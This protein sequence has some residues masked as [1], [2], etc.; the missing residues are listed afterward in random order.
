VCAPPESYFPFLCIQKRSG[1]LGKIQEQF[2]QRLDVKSERRGSLLPLEQERNRNETASK[3]GVFAPNN[4][5]LSHYQGKTGENRP[6]LFTCWIM[7]R[8]YKSLILN[9]LILVWQ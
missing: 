5:F 7:G 8:F 6:L 4:R 3:R 9:T 1:P 2:A